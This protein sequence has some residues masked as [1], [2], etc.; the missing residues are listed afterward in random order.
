MKKILLTT[1]FVLLMV[2]PAAADEFGG[3]WEAEVTKEMTVCEEIGR[4]KVGHYTIEVFQS[5]KNL[6]V[7]AQRPNVR[8]FGKF[9][10]DNPMAAHLQSTYEEDGGY[11]TELVDMVFNDESS[12]SGDVV[13]TWSDGVYSCGGT[14]SFVL[15]RK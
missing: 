12:A 14:Y 1:I 3:I 2:T 8:Y 6:I 15:N 10:E 13:W 5:D 7:Q 4:D 11:V 9:L